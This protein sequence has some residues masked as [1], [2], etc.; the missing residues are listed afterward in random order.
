MPVETRT[1]ENDETMYQA[2]RRVA[3]DRGFRFRAEARPW[4][5]AGGRSAD[6]IAKPS[7]GVDQ[8]TVKRIIHLGS[9]STDM[10]VHDVTVCIEVHVPHLLSDKCA[11]KHLTL[12]LQHE[13]EQQELLRGQLNRLAASRNSVTSGIERQIHKTVQIVIAGSGAA[14]QR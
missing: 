14:K 7:N 9:Q 10:D 2:V 5:A 8:L 4:C 12:V 6:N 3:S 1:S 13:G 11:G